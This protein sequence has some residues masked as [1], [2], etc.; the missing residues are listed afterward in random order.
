[1]WHTARGKKGK[2]LSRKKREKRENLL[3][4]QQ[5]DD[6]NS[7]LRRETI[8]HNVVEKKKKSKTVNKAALKTSTCPSYRLNLKGCGRSS[9]LPAGLRVQRNFEFS[10]SCP[11]MRFFKAAGEHEHE[12]RDDLSL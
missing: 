6:V 7:R 5:R 11:K 3:K 10:I 8:F 2:G 4:L 12:S 1:M 9:E